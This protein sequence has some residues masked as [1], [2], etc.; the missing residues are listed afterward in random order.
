[1]NFDETAVWLDGVFP[2]E[3]TIHSA[4]AE[5]FRVGT[6]DL[7]DDMLAT[8]LDFARVDTGLEAGGRDVRSEI[9]TVAHAG[10]GTE[11]FVELLRAL[12]TLLYDASGSLPAQP[13][14]LVP[15]VGIE[16]F[17]DTDITVRHGLFVVPYVW[18]GEVP[19]CDEPDRLTVMLQLVMLTQEEFDYAVTYGIPELQSEIA[20]SGIDLL[21]WSR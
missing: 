21:D 17:D 3:L 8:T 18:G 4:P 16:P 9:F 20:R 14:Q 10:V 5:S 13:G 15:A 7:G 19:Q 1:M 11:K 12:G 6:V 2:G